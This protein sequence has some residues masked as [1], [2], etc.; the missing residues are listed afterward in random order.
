MVLTVPTLNMISGALPCCSAA[1]GAGLCALAPVAP[2][3]RWACASSLYSTPISLPPPRPSPLHLHLFLTARC[4]RIVPRLCSNACAGPKNR[5]SLATRCPCLGPVCA[6]LLLA[7]ASGTARD[8]IPVCLRAVS[9]ADS[10]GLA[11]LVLRLRRAALRASV[12]SCV[13][14]Q[15]S[16]RRCPGCPFSMV[17]PLATLAC[18]T[19]NYLVFFV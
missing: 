19:H 9:S 8:P 11:R 14:P 2:A 12:T 6:C 15:R 13:V 16:A 17:A 3:R 7:S 10:A 18:P 5:L 4:L 1:V